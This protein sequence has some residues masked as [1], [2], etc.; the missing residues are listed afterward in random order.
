[1]R[2]RDNGSGFGTL[3]GADT[4]DVPEAAGPLSLRSRVDDLAGTLFLTSSQHG[5]EILIEVPV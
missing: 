4:E 3:A 5:T 2:I 1:M